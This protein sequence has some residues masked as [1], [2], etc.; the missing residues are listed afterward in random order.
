MPLNFLSVSIKCCFAWFGTISCKY[1]GVFLFSTAIGSIL[2]VFSMTQNIV[3]DH[4]A[5]TLKSM[6][7]S[8]DANHFW[9]P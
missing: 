2:F 4:C 7:S 3:S 8:I 6:L 5:F 1:D 9:L